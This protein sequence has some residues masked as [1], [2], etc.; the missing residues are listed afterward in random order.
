MNNEDTLPPFV[1]ALNNE[2]FFLDEPYVSKKK[3]NVVFRDSCI[4]SLY[5]VIKKTLC[6]VDI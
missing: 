1:C 4:I 2:V 5:F 3:E 6:S